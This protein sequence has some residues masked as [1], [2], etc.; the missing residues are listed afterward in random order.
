MVLVRHLVETFNNALFLFLRWFDEFKMGYGWVLLRIRWLQDSARSEILVGIPAELVFGKLR[1]VVI[2]KQ[3]FLRN[4]TKLA[5]CGYKEYRNVQF[6][7]N[8]L[9]IEDYRN[10]RSPRGKPLVRFLSLCQ[11]LPTICKQ[12]LR[13]Y[14]FE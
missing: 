12:A 9:R 13:M 8:K 3:R 2:R 1:R 10:Q 14:R 7:G 4:C 11:S 6:R 5:M